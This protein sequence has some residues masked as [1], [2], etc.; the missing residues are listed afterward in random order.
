MPVPTRAG[1][2]L[3]ATAVEELAAAA[4]TA[5]RSAMMGPLFAAAA[6]QEGR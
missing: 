1:F 2:I 6:E 5:A 4:R 3:P